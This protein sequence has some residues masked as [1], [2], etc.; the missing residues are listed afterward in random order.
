VGGHIHRRTVDGDRMHSQSQQASRRFILAGAID[1]LGN[2]IDSP[3][4]LAPLNDPSEQA[5]STPVASP[6]ANSGG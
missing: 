2:S 4:A 1:R 6:L 3:R 5:L